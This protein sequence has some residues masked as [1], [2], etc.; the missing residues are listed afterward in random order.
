[1]KSRP[2][3]VVGIEGWA[4]SSIGRGSRCQAGLRAELLT[5]ESLKRSGLLEAAT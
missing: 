2:G 5:Q 4:E 3:I 1:M